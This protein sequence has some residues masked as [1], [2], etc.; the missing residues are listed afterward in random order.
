MILLHHLITIYS[1]IINYTDNNNNNN[2]DNTRRD[3]QQL[4]NNN[5]QADTYISTTIIK[6]ND[7][8]IKI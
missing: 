4:N 8:N 1:T 6:T 2:I 5:T 3:E 7:N